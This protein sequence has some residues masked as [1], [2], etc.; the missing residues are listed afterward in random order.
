MQNQCHQKFYEETIIDR[1]LLF[2]RDSLKLIHVD[3]IVFVQQLLKSPSSR[4]SYNRA[5]KCVKN[6]RVSL[7][8]ATLREVHITTLMSYCHYPKQKQRLLQKMLHTLLHSNAT[9]LDEYLL[10]AHL[11]QRNFLPTLECYLSE[12]A[13]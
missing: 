4:L 6:R 13:L 5:Q 8:P 3:K 9:V 11:Y 12:K 2:L 7:F 10:T 1:C